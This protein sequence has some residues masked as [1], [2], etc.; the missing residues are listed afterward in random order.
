MSS[1]NSVITLSFNADTSQAKKEISNLVKELDS[2][3]TKKIS[4]SFTQGISQEVK[5]AATEVGKF[6]TILKQATNIDT[7]RLDLSKLNTGLKQANTSLPKMANSFK[8]LGSDGVRAFSNIVK[9]I[10]A[11]EVPLKKTN[12]LVDKMWDNLKKTAGWQISSSV[13][14]GLMSG[15]QGAF[16]YAQDLNESLNNIRIVTGANVEQMA[17]FAAEANKAAKALNTT[18]TAYTD[19]SLIYFQQGLSTE[20]VKERADVTIKMA[21]VTRQSAEEVS[22]QLT[23]IWNNFDDGTKSLEYYADVLTKLGAATA[24]STDEIAGGLEKFAAVADTIGLSYEYAASALATITSNTR[25]SEEV[26]GTALKTIFARIQGLEL[27]DTLDDGTT[28]NKYSEALQ[29]VG[30]SIFN[31]NGELKKMDNILDEMGSKWQ[32]LSKDQQV[33]LAQT[34][35]GVRQY[36]QLVSLMDNWNNGDSDSMSANLA[37]AYGSTGEL[38]KQADI[39]ADS[40]EA[41]QNRVKASAETLYQSLINDDFFIDLLDSAS[42]FLDF[43]TQ[44]T[45]GLGGVKGLLATISTYILTIAKTKI[46]DEL[47]R[48]TAP[49]ETKKAKQDMETKMSA[50]KELS[51]MAETKQSSSQEITAL[52]T[53][54]KQSYNIQSKIVANLDKMSST[55]RAIKLDQ[56]AQYETLTQIVAEKGRSLD[57]DERQIKVLERSLKMQQ[58][59]MRLEQEKTSQ[60]TIEEI[61]SVQGEGN[62]LNRKSKSFTQDEIDKVNASRTAAGLGNLTEDQSKT[63]MMDSSNLSGAAKTAHLEKYQAIITQIN[64]ELDESKAKIASI[65]FTPVEESLK[66]YRATSE[67]VQS[68]MDKLFPKEGVIGPEFLS[69]FNNLEEEMQQMVIELVGGQDEFDALVRELNETQ[70]EA[71]ETSV[72]VGV[73][74]D[75]LEQVRAEG[76]NQVIAE[77]GLDA[78]DIQAAT[79]AIDLQVAGVSELKDEV[80]MLEIEGEKLGED[81]DNL[82]VELPPWQDQLV[83]AASAV[84]SLSMALSALKGM[85]DTLSNP[86]LTFWEKLGT[87]FTTLGSVIPALVMTWKSLSDSKIKDAISTALDTAATWANVDAKKAEAQANTEAATTQAAETATDIADAVVDTATDVGDAAGDA[88]KVV[89]ELGD[90]VVKLGEKSVKSGGKIKGGFTKVINAGKGVLT[91]YGSTIGSVAAGVAVAAVIIAGCAMAWQALNDAYNKNEIEAQKAEETAKNLAEAYTE[92]KSKY[93]ELKNTVSSYQSARDGLSELT[94]GT[95]EF[96]D[97]ITQ[98][99]EEALKL[100]DTYGDLIGNRYTVDKDGLIT[101]DD[102]ALEDI[103]NQELDKTQQAQSASVIANQRAREARAKANATEVHRNTVKGNEKGMTSEDWNETGQAAAVTTG[104]GAGI[105][106][107]AGAGTAIAGAATGAT[108]GSAVTVVGTLIGAAVGLIVGGVVGAVVNAIDDNSET[109]TE[110]SALDSLAK[111]YHLKGE[112][113]LTKEAIQ[114]AYGRDD[115]TDEEI[116]AIRDLCRELNANTVATEAENQA[117]ANQILADNEKVQNSRDADDIGVFAGEAY[118]KA[119]QEAMDKYMSDDYKANW[120]GVGSDKQKEAWARYAESEGLS[121]LKDYI[122]KTLEAGFRI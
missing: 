63:L 73:L 27:G 100:L 94:H 64:Q 46:S 91:K 98:A 77:T 26:V 69:S 14:H 113:A 87:I 109:D 30:I 22:N 79:S 75:A 74:A 68:V 29:T 92:T 82:P 49:S 44:V 10:N 16:Q 111:D 107:A 40:W 48:L 72:A 1:S 52:S 81:F 65:T 24:S 67:S 80:K 53:G 83:S 9:Q 2:L 19:A 115:M 62:L 85:W 33:A 25:Q 5:D 7:G 50:T 105:G 3:S 57:A 88:G 34:V 12:G 32:T 114:A 43:I 121:S 17:A 61:S 117:M 23:S 118:G 103:Q 42:K 31:S 76:A 108:V 56:L 6:S 112:S 95:A 89:G 35:A 11:A 119:T 4:T 122:S 96:R 20:E 101:I 90:D 104:V 8:T 38:Q 39:Y 70:A 59:A 18:T 97:Q 47:K 71:G 116:A 78:E 84:S 45:D 93:E 110:K 99:N 13:L 37:T 51:N 66:R 15:V 60:Q 102:E 55:T 21:N 28:L 58:R 120:L 54:Y 86:D 106:L 41:A 36:T